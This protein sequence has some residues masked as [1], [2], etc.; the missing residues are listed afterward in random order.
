[1]KLLIPLFCALSLIFQTSAQEQ[2]TP[3]PI[4][5]IYDASGSMWGQLDGKTKKEIASEVLATSV[6]NLPANQNIGLMAYGHRKK[7]DCNDIEFLV[8]LKNASKSN[9][10]NAVSKMNALGKTPLARSASLALNS[11]K[12]SKT[13]ATIILITDGIESCNGN[14]CDVVS[15]AKT[16]GID[17]KLHIV[18]FGLKEN[19]T[20]QLRCA[21]DAGGG[22]YYDAANAIALSEGLTEATSLSIDKP[23]GNFSVYA[24]KNG[25]P[26]DAWIKASKAGTKKVVDGSRIYRDSGWVYLPPGKYDIVINPL[27][28]TDIPGTSITIEMKEGDIKHENISFDGGTLEVITTNN[29]EGWDALVKMKDMASGKVAAQTRTYGGTKTMEV[30]AGNYKIT[31]Q[32]L[33]LKGSN[34]YF[35]VDDVEIKSNTPTPINHDFESGTAAIGV[36]TKS[37]ELIDASVNFKDVKT[38]KRVT[39]GR[40]YTAASSNPRS[41]LLNPGTYEVKIVTLGIHKGNSSTL[42]IQVK[43]GETT[44]KII[45]Y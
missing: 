9:I 19:E 4:L 36:Q 23:E 31:F 16:D 21:T 11:L 32:A 28:G 1:M 14:I 15:K 45:R 2:K 24:T 8:D 26:V 10:T 42:T 41:F 38:G 12:D 44:T 43:K 20:E 39:G 35:E 25:K 27:E 7:G 13:K 37:G 3:S 5:F 17:F 6:S 22:N 33:A 30:P 34:T 29:G 40:T 18:G